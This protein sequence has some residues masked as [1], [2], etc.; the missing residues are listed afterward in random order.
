MDQ[1]DQTRA[2]VSQ[3]WLAFIEHAYQVL[4]AAAARKM[5]KKLRQLRR[6]VQRADDPRKAMQQ[7]DHAAHELVAGCFIQQQGYTPSYEPAWDDQTPDWLFTGTQG[8]GSFF[9]DVVNFQIDEPIRLE[10]QEVFKTSDSWCGFLSDNG[11]RLYQ[12]I[13]T[14]AG[15]YKAL[16]EGRKLPYVVFL[17][18]YFDAVVRPAEV[19][20]CLFNAEHGLFRCH[21]HLSAVCQLEA[22]WEC[23][24]GIFFH[25]PDA[26][27]PLEGVSDR[28]LPCPVPAAGATTAEPK[29]DATACG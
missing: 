14:K 16:A 25:N 2:P 26:L 10:M 4:P 29:G 20:E 18:T 15:K 7:Y 28:S 21:P 24:N 3:R 9:G 8:R 17:Y 6:A 5:Q 1:T 22:G 12:S 19:R 27:H 23:W 11:Q 13:N